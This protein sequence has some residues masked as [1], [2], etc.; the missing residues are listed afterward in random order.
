M[1]V[2]T[3][4]ESHSTSGSRCAGLTLNPHPLKTKPKGCATKFDLELY[5][6]AA[7]LVQKLCN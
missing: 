3:G 5:T 2:P 7:R 1:V 6:G 4:Q